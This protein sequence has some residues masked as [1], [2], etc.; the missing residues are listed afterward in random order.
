[1]RPQ[2]ASPVSLSLS[3]RQ[4][5]PN[6]RCI[7]V[8]HGRPIRGASSLSRRIPELHSSTD[9]GG[10]R[11]RITGA[12]GVAWRRRAGTLRLR[13][14]LQGAPGRVCGRRLAEVLAVAAA[15]IQQSIT[16][17][18]VG[19]AIG[20][21]PAYASVSPMGIARAIVAIG[22]EYVETSRE[23]ERQHGGGDR[24]SGS[25]TRSW[26]AGDLLCHVTDRTWSR[27]QR[28][29]LTAKPHLPAPNGLTQSHWAGNRIRS[30]TAGLDV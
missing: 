10:M 16:R 19:A 29:K 30:I 24:G 27:R 12:G 23:S 21:N 25:E 4:R 5:A 2:G 11:K 13:P 17:K 1:M 14:H 3:R 18:A 8:T 28:R 15:I 6:I 7:P 26:H 9:W 20:R 22:G